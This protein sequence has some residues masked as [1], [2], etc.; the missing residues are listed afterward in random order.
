MTPL[1]KNVSIGH[2]PH[3]HKTSWHTSLLRLHILAQMYLPKWYV[4]ANTP[5]Q[6]ASIKY[7]LIRKLFLIEYNQQQH[8]ELNE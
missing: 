1:R 4:A 5:M 7:P 8:L 2:A 3:A 6:V